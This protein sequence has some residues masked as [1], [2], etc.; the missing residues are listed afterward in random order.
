VINT[1][2]TEEQQAAITS[3]GTIPLSYSEKTFEQL[4]TKLE[5]G[6]L[7]VEVQFELSDAIDSTHSKVLIDRYKKATRAL[8]S[9]T[10][11]AMYAGALSG[12]DP[13]KGGGIFW[14][15]PTAQCIRCHSYD[16]YGGSAGPRINGVGSRLTKEQLL[17]SLIKPSARIAL[18]YGIVSLEL[19]NSRKVSGI[20]Q[21][22]NKDSYL[23]KV[24]DKPDT[25]I[26]KA[27]VLKRTDA[28]S[29]MPPM[30]YLLT[31]KEIRDVIAFLA[32]LKDE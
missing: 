5:N 31:K 23:L 15:H 25:L 6:K 21:Q 1:R 18:G 16:D 3:L 29:S 27:D 32:A 19:K 9:D 17:E 7:P 20:L 14:G 8:S 12:G 11:Q 4:I 26:N 2:T 28:P 13:R 10:L 30:Q 22:V 24:G